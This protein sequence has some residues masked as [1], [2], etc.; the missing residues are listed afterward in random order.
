VSQFIQ[1][2]M[3]KIEEDGAIAAKRAG[4]R[5]TT[6]VVEIN[7]ATEEG[8]KRRQLC[9]IIRGRVRGQ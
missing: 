7:P 5:E 1:K 3:G 8:R 2:E 9:V 6:G 4:W